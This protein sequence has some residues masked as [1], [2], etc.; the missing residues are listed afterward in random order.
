MSDPI[1][2]EEAYTEAKAKDPSMQITF[3]VVAMIEE[4]DNPDRAALAL[5]AIEPLF[6]EAKM[7]VRQGGNVFLGYTVPWD[8][9]VR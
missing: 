7:K 4:G 5:A 2:I 3:R 6:P 9:R 1:S 8:G